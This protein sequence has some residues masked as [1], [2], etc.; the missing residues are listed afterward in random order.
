MLQFEERWQRKKEEARQASID[1][2]EKRNALSRIVNN[3]YKGGYIKVPQ[4][5]LDAIK[6]QKEAIKNLKQ[7]VSIFISKPTNYRYGELVEKHAIEVEMI[8]IQQESTII[9]F[10][11]SIRESVQDFED[12]EKGS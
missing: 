5:L 10:Q 9:Q 1:L 3:V 11:H 2:I 6:S 8:A 7:N 4:V 12:I